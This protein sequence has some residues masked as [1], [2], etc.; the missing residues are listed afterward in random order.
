[1]T[2]NTYWGDND[3]TYNIRTRTD[4][5]D[6][7]LTL[8]GINTKSPGGPGGPTE[9]TGPGSPYSTIMNMRSHDTDHMIQIS[10]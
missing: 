8:N 6:I 10:T 2:C 4:G 9:P 5:N 3:I 1:M 7:K